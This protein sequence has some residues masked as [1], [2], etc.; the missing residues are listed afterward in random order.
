MAGK[1][2]NTVIHVVHESEGP[3]LVRGFINEVDANNYF[4][5][6]VAAGRLDERWYKVSPMP[7]EDMG[8]PAL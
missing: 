5:H 8:K 6:E 1:N 4:N 3:H 2:A 7:L